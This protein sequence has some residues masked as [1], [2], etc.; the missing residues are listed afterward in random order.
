MVHPLPRAV[1]SVWALTAAFVMEYAYSLG[2]CKH[3]LVPC[4]NSDLEST[5][6]SIQSLPKEGIHLKIDQVTQNL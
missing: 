2:L 6:Q 4:S 5:P 1:A 3:K